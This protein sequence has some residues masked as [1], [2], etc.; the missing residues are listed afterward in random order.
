MKASFNDQFPGYELKGCFCKPIY[1]RC[2]LLLFALTAFSYSAMA[3]DLDPNLP[4]SGNFDL[5]YWKLTRPN[6][7]EIDEDNLSNGF[8]K[9][10]EF[11]TDPLQTLAFCR[12]LTPWVT[13]RHDYHS[14]DFTIYMRKDQVK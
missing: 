10:G 7:Q 4:P 8:V 13:L 1:F 9:E 6:Q 2:I 3:Q 12:T 14:R 5:S 11:Y